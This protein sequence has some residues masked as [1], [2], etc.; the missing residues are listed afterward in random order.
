MQSA[1]QT[2]FSLFTKILLASN[3]FATSLDDTI[4]TFVHSVC[5]LHFA[6]GKPKYRVAKPYVGHR[7]NAKRKTKVSAKDKG[8]IV[9]KGL[10]HQTRANVEQEKQSASLSKLNF[11]GFTLDTD[12]S[13]P[14]DENEQVDDCNLFAQLSCLQQFFGKLECPSCHSSG[15]IAFTFDEKRECGFA[16]FGILECEESQTIIHEDFLCCAFL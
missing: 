14:E 8:N 7:R 1:D 15:S 9:D 11:Y 4:P 3:F 10:G 13:M 5:L 16:K 6:M 12:V 2:S